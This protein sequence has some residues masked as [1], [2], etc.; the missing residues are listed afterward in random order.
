M[1]NSKVYMN[2]KYIGECE[3]FEYKEDINN[4]KK[5]FNI[6]ETYFKPELTF[7]LECPDGFKNLCKKIRKQPRKLKKKLYGT[8]SRRKKLIKKLKY[9]L[10]LYIQDFKK[11]GY[12]LKIKA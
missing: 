1:N 10:P 3:K 12:K 6:P 4:C 8:I 7:K 11:A 2:G 5:L 9:G